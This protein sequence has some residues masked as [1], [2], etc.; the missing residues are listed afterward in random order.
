MMSDERPS[1]IFIRLSRCTDHN[2][3]SPVDWAQVA[4]WAA[5][6]DR[7]RPMAKVSIG[8]CSCMPRHTHMWRTQPVRDFLGSGVISTT[9]AIVGNI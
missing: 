4:G 6:L 7:C 8:S 1:K 5:A 2:M 3:P 9:Y